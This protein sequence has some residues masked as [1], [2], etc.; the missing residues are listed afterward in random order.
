MPPC[1]LNLSHIKSK[2]MASS[3]ASAFF[4]STDSGHWFHGGFWLRMITVDGRARPTLSVALVSQLKVCCEK[5]GLRQDTSVTDVIQSLVDHFLQSR[6]DNQPPKRAR[7]SAAS[8][9]DR[10][11]FSVL[12]QRVRGSTT[13]A[14]RELFSETALSELGWKV[15][16]LKRRSLPQMTEEGR[17]M[18]SSFS[19]PWRQLVLLLPE[20]S[21]SVGELSRCN[22]IALLAEGITANENFRREAL[23]QELTAVNTLG[24]DFFESLQG[25]T[26]AVLGGA[27]AT[28]CP[29]LQ[30]LFSELAI[31]PHTGA[32][33]LRPPEVKME[34][35]L[36][37]AS[38]IAK[39]RNLR[40]C[41]FA[42]AL[43]VMW[44]S[45][46]VPS[47]AINVL[48][49]LGLSASVER[50]GKMTRDAVA[51]QRAS[52]D[53]S[54]LK[55]GAA[56]TLCVVFDNIDVQLGT[57][58]FVKSHD[59]VRS[60]LIHVTAASVIYFPEMVQPAGA[61]PVGR[62]PY[63]ALFPNA[64][65]EKR[66]CA[67]ICG[68][69]HEVLHPFGR[70]EIGC[71]KSVSPPPIVDHGSLE[72]ARRQALPIY[73]LEEGKVDDMYSFTR[74][75]LS[76]FRTGSQVHF[77][78]DCFSLQ[79]LL[80]VR[81]L[82]VGEDLTV[83]PDPEDFPVVLVPGWFHLYWNVFL[84]SLLSSDRDLLEMFI[85]IS[86]RRNLKLHK[87]IGTCFNDVDHIATLLL[88]V[89]VL[90]LFRFFR[91]TVAVG[92]KIKL[93]AMS[94][95]EV[96]L[97]FTTFVVGTVRD[98]GR[99]SKVSDPKPLAEWQRYCRVVLLLCVYRSLRVAIAAQNHAQMMDVLH[100]SVS[101]VCQGS[102]RQYRKVIIEAVA[103]FARSSPSEKARFMQ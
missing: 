76:K 30:Q 21:R 69:L 12:P 77:V 51:V 18:L 103:H 94:E 6:G 63:S 98:L 91:E 86:D 53:K 32:N 96:M 29:L 85:E 56:Q 82:L 61:R 4:L 46:G 97:A 22:V 15:T 33:K 79:K 50:G 45:L 75:I 3:H 20:R 47:D 41:G 36:I 72:R 88:P 28:R 2:H 8:G 102:F 62:L 48:A 92:A 60:R 74:D 66:L 31:G 78:G 65:C 23:N 81:E 24:N 19:D 26:V 38:A 87:D 58:S 9:A 80:I 25:D 57:R 99:R 54:L 13:G 93:A 34:W 59:E 16:Q 7:E 42:D 83:R 71:G 100:F 37:L 35:M 39:V 95:S 11:F 14:E 101:L 55:Y 17:S 84:G 67:G 90:R 89:V 40:N 27:F 44:K 52:L 43:Y 64:D 10:D 49:N 70:V 73:W 68:V 1:C 5:L